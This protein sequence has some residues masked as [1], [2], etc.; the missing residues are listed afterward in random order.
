[1]LT[2]S[3]LTMSSQINII[4]IIIIITYQ[5]K[6]SISLHKTQK[7]NPISY[8]T[9]TT[10]HNTLSLALSSPHSLSLSNSEPNTNQHSSFLSFFLLLSLFAFG[11]KALAVIIQTS[12]FRFL[13]SS[14]ITASPLGLVRSFFSVFLFSLS[15]SNVDVSPL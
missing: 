11:D 1:M 14:S 10:H 7:Q 8:F 3:L 4:I 12:T 5:L 2:W 13:S 6:S 15:Q 9:H